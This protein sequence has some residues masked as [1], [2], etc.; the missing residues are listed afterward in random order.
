MR[1]RR[2]PIAARPCLL[3]VIA[4]LAVFAVAASPAHAA[5]PSTPAQ[6]KHA[7]TQA[8]AAGKAAPAL[9]AL[10]AALRADPKWKEG[11]WDL[12][13][14]L[15]EAHDVRGARQ[16]FGRLAQLDPKHGAP[17]AMLGLCDFEARDFGRSLK[18]LQ[19]GRSLGLPNPN[20]QAVALY[21]EAQD[22]LML[23][24]F[25]QAR[26]LLRGFALNHR[27]SPGIVQ[28]FGLAALHLP[29]LPAQS[30][31]VLSARRRRL[32]DAMGLAVYQM[33]ARKP[34]AAEKA[35]AAVVHAFPRVPYVQYN[36][37][38]LLIRTSHLHAAARAFQRELQVQPRNVPARLQLAALRVQ[39]AQYAQ[40]M[41]LARQALRLQADN[42]ATHYMVG[43]IAFRQ[44]HF[45]EAA[46]QL[47]RAKALAPENS[48]VR[49][50]LAQTDLRLHREK[51]ALREERD[52]RRL[53]R[54]SS[55]FRNNGVL[56]ASVYLHSQP[57]S[58][59]P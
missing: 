15:Y 40:A 54:L 45:A 28:A 47:A 21:D 23:E 22:L 26:H 13:T 57:H 24:Q 56:P 27:T 1:A 7:A 37:G 51:A 6:L 55:S 5:T 30:G 58:G 20:L 12:G 38:I 25:P 2:P 18:H 14:L 31:R 49:Y 53:E 50:T 33:E 3:A 8:V 59:T 46:R 43:Y 48:Q 32:V 44:G 42:F 16:A 11:L 9:H 39:S 35:M 19:E 17:W 29:V 41:S 10:T 52:F 4:S 36:D 34:L